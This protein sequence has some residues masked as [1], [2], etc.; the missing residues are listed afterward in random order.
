MNLRISIR[1]VVSLIFSI[2][3]LVSF[4]TFSSL[5]AETAIFYIG[6]PFTL[7][8]FL[9]SSLLLHRGN[10][11]LSFK[12]AHSDI[13]NIFIY[14]LTNIFNSSCRINARTARFQFLSARFDFL[15]ESD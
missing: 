8:V 9:F 1:I 7:S 5:F 10:T 14:V 4:W 12:I 6:L 3:T 15:G 13:V 11:I 2:F